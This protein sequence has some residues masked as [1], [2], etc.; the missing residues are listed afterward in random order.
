VL[1]ETVTSTADTPE[2]PVHEGQEAIERAYA[3]AEREGV[4][5]VAIERYEEGYAFTYDLLPAGKRL[6]PTMEKEVQ[7]RLTNEL[8][9]IV[10][11]DTRTVEVSKS[12]NDSLGHVSLLA[13]EAEARRVAQAVAPFVLDRANWLEA[14]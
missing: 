1:L 2:V 3:R 8:E 14:R 9:D 13:S 11:S 6:T 12:V 5:F 4:P 7:V 10:G